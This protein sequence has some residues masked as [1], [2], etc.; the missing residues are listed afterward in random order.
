VAAIDFPHL[1]ECL[2]LRLIPHT[3]THTH[4]YIGRQTG[5]PDICEHL[6]CRLFA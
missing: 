6:A 1:I 3:S 5:V 2:K 4:P